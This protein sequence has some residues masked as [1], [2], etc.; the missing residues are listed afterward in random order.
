LRRWQGEPAGDG[1]EMGEI[2]WAD[3]DDPPQPLLRSTRVGFELY[4]A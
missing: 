1:E 3:L 2:V 4:R